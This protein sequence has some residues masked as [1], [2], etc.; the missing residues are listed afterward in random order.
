MLH[1]AERVIPLVVLSLLS[2]A[3]VP[4]T[5][6]EPCQDDDLI[7]ASS[8]VPIRVPVILAVDDT[9]QEDADIIPAVNDVLRPTGVRLVVTMRVTWEGDRGTMAG[10]LEQ[11][12]DSVPARSNQ[13]V[14]GLTGRDFERIDGMAHKSHLVARQHILYENRD[15]ALV[16][17][18]I[19]HVLGAEHD[20]CCTECVMA[21][22]SSRSTEWC[23]RDAWQINDNARELVE[24]D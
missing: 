16:A 6:Q 23:A 13:V 11:L 14:I 2:L 9:W 15:A 10:M 24:E 7:N 19:G 4:A 5:A 1:L 3:L 22:T 18:E 21:P 20:T 12:E 8:V 17:H